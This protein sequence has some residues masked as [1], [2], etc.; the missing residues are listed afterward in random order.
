L[1]REENKKDAGKVG[2]EK[3]TYR[4]PCRPD[5]TGPDFSLRKGRNRREARKN[6]WKDN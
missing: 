4:S 2:M 6:S 1:A 3:E 5:A